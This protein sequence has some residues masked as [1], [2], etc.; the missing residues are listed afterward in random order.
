M[1]FSLLGPLAVH[2]GTSTRTLDGPKARALLAALLLN[3]NQPVSTDCLQE[4]L[5]GERPP[6]TARASLKNHV[7]RLRRALA[8]DGDEEP[9]VRA[10][11]GG[12]VLRVGAGE[13]DADDFTGALALAR[14]AYLRQDWPTVSRETRRAASLWRGTP[15]PELAY[16]AEAQPHVERYTQAR[17]QALEWRIDAELA[18]GRH[19]GL[20]PELTGLIT[21]QPLRETF[22][23][24]LMLVLHRTGQ[25]AEALAVFG[26]LRRT[27]VDELG[28]EPG[29]DVL[30]A[31]QEILRPSAVPASATSPS[32]GPGDEQDREPVRDAASDASGPA[33]TG[34]V[35]QTLDPPAGSVPTP[36]GSGVPLLRGVLAEAAES[37]ARTMHSR[38]IREEEQRRIHDPFPLPVRW[39]SAPAGLLDHWDNISGTPP[40]TTARTLSLD[41]GLA[42]VADVYRRIGSGRLVVLG[43]AG[44]GKTVLMTRFVLDH[45][46][47]RADSDPV[48]VIFSIGSWDPTVTG[49]RDW[50][51]DRLLRDHPNL[52]ARAPGYSTLA[53]ALVDSGWILPVLDGFDEIATGLH[54]AA[55]QELNAVSLP[56]LLTSRTEQFADAAATGVLRKAAG[57]ELTDLTTDDLA[58]YLPRSARPTGQG[59]D[60]GPA[61]TVWDPVLEELRS[62]PD[63]RSAANLAVVLGTPL[64]VLLARTLYSDTPGQDPADLLDTVR[65]P[66]PQAL[67]QHLLAGFVPTVYRPRPPARADAAAPQPHR[68]WTLERVRHY[69]GHLAGSPDR[70]EQHH[71]G[72]LAWWQLSD[73]LSLPSRVLAIVLACTAVTTVSNVLV[74]SVMNL[75]G[76]DCPFALSTCVLTGLIVGPTV[77]LAFGLVYGI[78]VVFGKEAFDPSHVR[79]QLPG[80]GRRKAA[81]P[82][83]R[84]PI[85]F[86]AGLLVG[87]AV[88]VAYIPTCI[89]VPGLHWSRLDAGAP[90]AT[91]VLRSLLPGAVYG[92]AGGLALGLM[93]ALETPLD[94]GSA[95]TPARLLAINRT[96]V[97]RQA[98]LVAPVTTIAVAGVCRMLTGSLSRGL[99]GPEVPWGWLAVA[100]ECGLIGTLTYVLAFTAWGQWLLFTRI[101]LPLTGRLPWS[102]MAFLDD[103]H[104]R[105]VLRQVGAVYQFRHARL[106]GHLRR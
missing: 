78:A 31:H 54:R 14:K 1:R 34:H 28:V 99:S 56:L 103:A 26:R 19:S 49:L 84:L 77:G 8:E 72:D 80:R 105:G 25:Q 48:P 47:G 94:V 82:A 33:A 95:A 7:A 37:L 63:S 101:A 62:R 92:T 65:F 106:Q 67:E 6:A 39:R 52:A 55:L 69:L 3:P 12:Y 36:T 59:E 83:R 104:R 71:R 40:G 102:T 13:L 18:L 93:A 81:V 66:T 91:L 24:Q 30:A 73:A 85:V 43:Q 23:R 20:A 11:P 75:V 32:H 45:L 87:L 4:T 21:E 58:H 35:S 15:M 51:I 41:G 96:T 17:W 16:L 64:M 42:Q 38:G 27:L 29:A 2:D 97:I 10:V 53:A 22:H 60:G 90:V 50:L 76:L 88:G 79:L 46:A 5:W 70:P 100:F 9:R 68:G 74:P 44:S 57:I 86:G 61:S 89:L 98:L